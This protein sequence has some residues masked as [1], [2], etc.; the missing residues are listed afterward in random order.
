MIMCGIIGFLSKHQQPEGPLGGTLLSMLQA[1][2]CRGPDSAGVAVFGP[3][4]PYWL[5]QIKLPEIDEVEHAANTILDT[6]REQARVALHHVVG[7]YLR[8]E[9]DG[10]VDPVDLEETLL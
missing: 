10:S 5:L 2:S 4:S 8:L 1:L 3:P 9:V 7:A 6:V